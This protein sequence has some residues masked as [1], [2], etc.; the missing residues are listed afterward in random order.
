MN[1]LAYLSRA[2]F[3]S[4]PGRHDWKEP[5]FCSSL[6]FLPQRVWG[7]WVGK[8]YFGFHLLHDSGYR[9]MTFAACQG[10]KPLCKV[11]D[12]SDV[13][14]LDGIG[15]LGEWKPSAGVPRLVLPSGWEIDCLPRSGLLHLWPSSGRIKCME[16]IS[17]F[18]VY[19]VN[20]EKGN[21]A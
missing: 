16:S 19:A 6:V 10:E 20:K 11:T 3:E 2:D 17:S 15:G 18:E 8:R 5:L 9:F 7:L 12:Q 4:L 21:P 13:L 1:S 14:H